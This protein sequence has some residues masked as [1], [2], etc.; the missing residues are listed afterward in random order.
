MKAR[1]Y[2]QKKNSKWNYRGDVSPR[3]LIELEMESKQ[4][5]ERMVWVLVSDNA[6][7]PK[8]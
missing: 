2:T 8:R 6:E 3:Q 1:V 5:S 4:N 7:Q